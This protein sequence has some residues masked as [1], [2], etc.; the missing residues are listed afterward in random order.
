MHAYIKTEYRQDLI[1][2]AK[3][4]FRAAVEMQDDRALRRDRELDVVYLLGS[5]APEELPDMEQLAEP[6]VRSAIEGML[7]RSDV[8]KRDFD[9]AMSRVSLLAHSKGFPFNA[10][11]ELMLVLPDER[12]TDRKSV[13]FAGLQSY[14]EFP[15]RNEDGMPRHD[16]MATFILRF[17]KQMP[18]ETVIDA[19]DLVLKNSQAAE[20]K[21]RI[22]LT[23]KNYSGE[24]NLESPYKMRLFELL[25]V[26]RE[27]EP[28]K[29]RE[30]ERDQA[31]R[32][33]LTKYPNGLQSFEPAYANMS[34]EMLNYLDESRL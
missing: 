14:R 7:F 29:A 17:W 16:D 33:A 28:S 12:T 24:V 8:K 23:L 11:T 5:T 2:S 34:P 26:L 13:F 31:M 22:T 9:A 6:E 27:L 21:A 25:P 20:Q 18:Q 32:D 19:M 1:R 15:N 10:A 30:L 4:C 3:A